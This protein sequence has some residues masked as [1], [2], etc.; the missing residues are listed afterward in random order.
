MSSDNLPYALANPLSIALN[1]APQEFQRPDFLKIIKE[2]S[3]E[4]VTFH[5]T[6]LDGRLKELRIPVSN[7]RR[8]EFVLAEGERVDGSSLFKGMIDVALSDLYVVP[9]YK[10]AFLSPFDRGSLDFICRYITRDGERAPFTPDAILGKA[11]ELLKKNTGVELNALGE[12]EFFL[13]GE[14]EPNLFPMQKQ[15]GYQESSPFVKSGKIL[16]EMVALLTKITGA[17]KYAHSENGS[18][19]RL[20]SDLDEIKG[21]RAEQLEIEFLS[22]PVTEMADHLV[23][24]R[25]LI[26]NVA[27]KHGCTATFAPKL[28]EGIAGNGLH[29]HLKLK[30]DGASLMVEDDGSLS[31]AAHRLIGG[32]CEHAE[33]LTAFGNTTASSYL[34]LD[35]ELEA[36]TRIF[37]SALNR[38]AEPESP[39]PGAVGL[40]ET[41]RSCRHHQPVRGAQEGGLGEPANGRIAEPRWQ[42]PGT[43]SP[44]RDR[45]GNGMGDDGGPR[46]G[47]WRC[48]SFRRGR[49]G[50]RLGAGS[51]GKL[52]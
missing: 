34:R 8:T 30:R 12:L 38:K 47:A 4:R 13:V 23:L 33:S 25:W 7:D 24:G 6:A 3:I 48:A 29:F 16:N 50:R 21:K 19:D 44:G 1:K 18:I 39:D 49:A 22:R 43:S 32:L 52:C 36:P 26:R 14:R 35:P 10:T 9:E 46:A 20:Q 51:A 45:H 27:Y 15:S 41:Q 2:K 42:R 31:P 37:W 5:F 11:D 28:E 17:V 40:V